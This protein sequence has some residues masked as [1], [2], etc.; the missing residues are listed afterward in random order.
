M[1]G[2]L[3]IPLINPRASYLACKEEIDAASARVMESGRYILGQEVAAFE[4]EFAAYI[5]VRCG[6]GVGSGTDALHLALRACGVGL[7]DEVITVSHT[8]VATPA[9]I[10]LCGA[11]PVFVDI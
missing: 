1:L 2:P 9:A 10:E 6:I 11:S 4:E 8:A 5:G 7:G 3:S